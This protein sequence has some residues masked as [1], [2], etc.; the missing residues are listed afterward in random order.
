[1]VDNRMLVLM[2]DFAGVS[3]LSIKIDDI[4]QFLMLSQYSNNSTG[5]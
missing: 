2:K 5:V 1:M 3:E 4:D